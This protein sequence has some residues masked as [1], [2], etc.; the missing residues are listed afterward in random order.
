MTSKPERQTLCVVAIL[1]VATLLL[2][3][4][5]L[6]HGFVDYD[7]F[8]YVVE[9]PRVLQGLTWDNLGWAFTSTL[10]H[11]WHPLTMLSHMLDVTLFGLN[12]GGHHFVSILFHA[13]NGVLL[14]VVLKQATG[15][16]WPSAAAAALFAWHPLHVESV[17][18][19]AERK[20]VLSMFFLLLTWWSYNKYAIAA[21]GAGQAQTKLRR[22]WYVA[23]L[24]F[25]AAGLM[26][27]PMLVTLPFAL[28]LLDYWP[29]HRL[30]FS[31]GPLSWLRQNRSVL[32]EKIPFLALTLGA[33]FATVYAQGDAIKPVE[34]FP[35]VGRIQNAIVSYAMYLWKTV[36]PVELAIFYPHPR[37]LPLSSVAIAASVLG[38]IS[39]VVWWLRKRFPF[40]V[41]GWCW[42]LGTLVPVIGLVQVGSAAMADRY[43]YIPHIGIFIMLIWTTAWSK[44]WTQP[45]MRNFGVAGTCIILATLCV[46][47]SR[48]LEHW[49]NSETLFRHAIHTTKNN[50][51]A[52]FNLGVALFKQERIEEAL[53]HFETALA[54]VPGD[55]DAHGY[56]GQILCRL[57]RIEEGAKH[58]TAAEVVFTERVSK[59]E[60]GRTVRDAAYTHFALGMAQAMQKKHSEAV[61]SY[62]KA[63]EIDPSQPTPYNELAWILATSRDPSVRNGAEAVKAAERACELTEWKRVAFIGTLD[64]AYAEAGRFEDAIVTAQRVMQIGEEQHRGYLAELAKE[65]VKLYQQGKPYRQ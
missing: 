17:A 19:V 49:R 14:F 65:R 39:A 20:D 6:W 37:T 15:R 18:W 61:A 62:R 38:I 59:G 12:A 31:G 58:L 54:L 4:P 40:L 30:Q 34:L 16:L 9:N 29:L 35:W 24:V 22:R 60:S 64:T 25:F 27:K 23:A 1:A 33:C 28:L 53:P 7:D 21:A 5:T 11:N 42:Y 3:S 63:I 13:I 44:L 45:A 36:Y 46:L 26:S 48:Q 41:T 52:N 32:L 10:V 56:I 8:D 2:Y 50:A 57:G 43:T 47:T 55:P 51:L